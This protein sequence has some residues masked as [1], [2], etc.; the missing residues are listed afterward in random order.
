[1]W[2]RKGFENILKLTRNIRL[3]P[4]MILEAPL[5]NIFSL[6]LVDGKAQILCSMQKQRL[7]WRFLQ[8]TAR[9]LPS[10][11]WDDSQLAIDP[12]K[13][14]YQENLSTSQRK[15]TSWMIL[16][17]TGHDHSD[18]VVDRQSTIQS[19]KLSSTCNSAPRS[20]TGRFLKMELSFSGWNLRIETWIE[21][22]EANRSEHY[23][24]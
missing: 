19:V 21:K 13:A 15:E 10:D 23:Q 4:K 8:K 12:T 14:D 5:H 6:L 9:E 2:T 3:H 1:M 20:W 7:E 18:Y 17:V 22:A 16:L 24:V 11:A